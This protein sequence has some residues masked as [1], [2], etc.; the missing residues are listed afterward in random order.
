MILCMNSMTGE[1]GRES[2]VGRCSGDEGTGDDWCCV[3]LPSRE[4]TALPHQAH[5]DIHIE[6]LG[7]FA[8]GRFAG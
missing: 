4:M 3:V 8:S 7:L 2:S 5:L 1:A 6:S